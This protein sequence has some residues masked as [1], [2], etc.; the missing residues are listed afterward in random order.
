[1]TRPQIKKAIAIAIRNV[2]VGDAGRSSTKA[3]AAEK[4]AHRLAARDP[5]PS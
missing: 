5:A 2:S 1:M 3:G 4:E